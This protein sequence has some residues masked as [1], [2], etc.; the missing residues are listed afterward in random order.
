VFT[1]GFMNEEEPLLLAN[2]LLE[3]TGMW[4]LSWLRRDWVNQTATQQFRVRSRLPPQSP[5]GRHKLWLC[6]KNKILGCEASI[7]EYKTILKKLVREKGKLCEK[8]QHYTVQYIHCN[9]IVQCEWLKFS[10]IINHHLKWEQE[11]NTRW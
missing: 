1:L 9:F 8:G 5:E 6:I 7:P 2:Y 11:D 3:K 10:G 4:W